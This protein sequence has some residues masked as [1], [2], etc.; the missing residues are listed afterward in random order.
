MARTPATAENGR[1]IG[2]AVDAVVFD[3]FGTVV[4]WRT[5]VAREF[6][7]VGTRAGIHADW[8]GL[9]AAWR[10]RY[11]PALLRVVSGEVPWRSLDELHRMMLDDVLTEHRLTEFTDTDRDELVSAW[12]RLSP[13][14]DSRDGLSQLRESH[15]TATLSNGSTALLIHL[16][17]A[18]RLPFDAILSAELIH[19]YKPDPKVYLMAAELLEVPP[20]RLLM[21]A[22]HLE[23]LRAAADA[24]L[25]TAY[26]PRPLEWGP[27]HPAPSAP[28]WVDLTATDVVHLARQLAP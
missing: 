2:A 10:S 24:G 6:E 26:I 17:R 22:C 4:D 19:S 3:V 1:R 23:D 28:D 13:W 8:P 20:S 9:T 21:T 14:P 16:A 5:G 12:H 27:G 15:I 18:G 11:P 7:R 25:R